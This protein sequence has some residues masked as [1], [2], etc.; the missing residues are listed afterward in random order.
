[1][2]AL[3]PERKQAPKDAAAFC[4]IQLK[5]KVSGSSFIPTPKSSARVVA[6]SMATKARDS[7]FLRGERFGDEVG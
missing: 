7:A 4:S 2:Y 3:N 1:M 6:I 5:T